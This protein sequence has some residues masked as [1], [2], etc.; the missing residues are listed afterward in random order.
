MN[1]L[2]LHGEAKSFGHCKAHV[3]AELVKSQQIE[4]GDRKSF[5]KTFL[6][7]ERKQTFSEFLESVGAQLSRI[8][9]MWAEKFDNRMRDKHTYLLDEDEM[10]IYK[11]L[12]NSKNKKRLYHFHEIV[13]E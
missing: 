13:H 4:P 12:W 7:S 11:Q 1:Y 2:N 10:L 3:L 6:N 9:W 5:L 8:N